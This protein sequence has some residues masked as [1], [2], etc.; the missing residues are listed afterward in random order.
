MIRKRLAGKAP[1]IRA[2]ADWRQGIYAPQFTAATYAGL[3]DEAASAL[4]SGTGAI[5]D[6]TFKDHAERLRFRDLARRMAVPIVFAECA[7]SDQQAKSRLDARALQPDAVSDATWDIYLRAQGGVRSVRRGL[8][9]LSSE[10]RGRRRPAEAA[11]EIERFMV[12][13]Q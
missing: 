4:K 10:G 5:I 7:I 13:H 6:A 2:G 3:L 11:W 8:C 12:S 9:R 1:T